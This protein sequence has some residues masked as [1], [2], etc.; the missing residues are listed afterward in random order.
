MC[1]GLFLN[2]DQIGFQCFANYV[3]IRKGVVDIYHFNRTVVHPDYNGLG[4]GIRLINET[5]K[6]VKQKYGFKIM[7][8]FSSLP[9]YK[10]MIKQSCWRYLGTKRLM[11]KMKYGSSIKKNSGWREYGIKTYHFEFIGSN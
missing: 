6:H 3:P 5:S 2:G 9:V 10:A 7:G 8:K 4:L 1:Y 11:G